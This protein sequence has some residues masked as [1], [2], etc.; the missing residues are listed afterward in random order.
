M[1]ATPSRPPAPRGLRRR[2]K[3]LW[4]SVI[5]V[6][7]PSPA[8]L[9][10]LHEFCSTVDEIDAFKAVLRG[11]S[12]VVSG[13]NGQ[14]RPNPIYAELRRHRELADRLSRSLGVPGV[15]DEPR[16]SFA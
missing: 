16:G 11:C 12:P 15:L 13:S 3:A 4:D 2:G 1:V 10:I 14:P 7:E 8:E 6:G 9:A 5:E